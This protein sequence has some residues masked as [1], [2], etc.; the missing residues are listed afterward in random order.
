MMLRVHLIGTDLWVGKQDP[1]YAVLEGTQG[2]IRTPHAHWWAPEDRAKVWTRIRD[3]K[4]VVT[5]GLR[6]EFPLWGTM[7][8]VHEDGSTKPLR[9]VVGR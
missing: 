8:V 1:T 6:T 4:S 5:Q 2:P 7:E 3:L 9:E